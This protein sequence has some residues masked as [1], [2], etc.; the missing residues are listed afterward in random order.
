[1]PTIWIW[2][3]NHFY[4]AHF[5]AVESLLA[6]DRI[7]MASDLVLSRGEAQ[8]LIKQNAVRWHTMKQPWE[9]ET[10]T[11]D[12]I[13]PKGWPF[14]L[15]IGK[16]PYRQA[17]RPNPQDPTQMRPA[18]VKAGVEMMIPL[19]EQT[20]EIWDDVWGYPDFPKPI[21]PLYAKILWWLELEW[22]WK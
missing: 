2:E 1:M 22:L 13:L 6:V 10:C 21:S 15:L 16:V 12:T 20:L 11:L 14:F 7:M 9:W 3:T 18:F 17:E 8:R 19:P 4:D 5:R